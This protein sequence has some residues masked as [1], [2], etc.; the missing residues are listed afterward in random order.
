MGWLPEKL[1]TFASIGRSPSTGRQAHLGRYP[2]TNAQYARF[3]QPENFRDPWLWCGFPRY[4]AQ[5][6]LIPESRWKKEWGDEGWQWLQA[7]LQDPSVAPQGTVVY[8]RT[9]FDPDY[10]S[11]RPGAP[12]VGVTWYEA[13][14]YC[15]WLQRAWAQVE[16][17][18][19]N[20]FTPA[21]LRLPT[22]KEWE[23]AAGGVKEKDRYPWDA[24]GQATADRAEILARS[25]VAGEIGRTTPVGMYQ[26]GQSQLKIW[27]L[28][29]NVWEW[30][31]NYSNRDQVWLALRGG[32][33][34]NN[35]GRARVAA[36]LNDPP[37]RE[38]YNYG[39]RVVAFP[40]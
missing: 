26:D 27:D 24:E 13:N 2:V 5:G 39:F 12:V 36:R 17:G 15:R 28:A 11:A 34:D 30:Q 10:G 31:A 37:S 29:G 9:W 19:E 40:S 32:G 1:S 4:D 16:E 18:R 20:D 25:N 14:A 22:E 33:W 38:W 6:G 8:P 23:Q 21:E 7:R 35:V 3:L